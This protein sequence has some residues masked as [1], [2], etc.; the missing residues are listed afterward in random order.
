MLYKKYIRYK[1]NNPPESKKL[2]FCIKIFK[3]DHAI[4]ILFQESMQ[5][6]IILIKAL[7]A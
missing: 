7:I 2:F 4:K 6:W 3:H 1:F 5:N